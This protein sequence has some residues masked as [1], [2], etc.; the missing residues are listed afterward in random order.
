MGEQ[1]ATQAPA[2]QHTATDHQSHKSAFLLSVT[3][4]CIFLAFIVLILFPPAAEKLREK[5]AAQAATTHCSAA[6]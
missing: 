6:I 2:A 3:L 1:E 4:T 5:L